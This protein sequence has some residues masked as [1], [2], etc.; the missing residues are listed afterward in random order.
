MLGIIPHEHLKPAMAHDGP[1]L[2]SD[3]KQNVH[4]TAWSV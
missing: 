1:V 2:A 4:D 3:E